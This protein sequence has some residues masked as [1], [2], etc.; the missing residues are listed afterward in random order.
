M[1]NGVMNVLKREMNPHWIKVALD[2]VRITRSV[3]LPSRNDRKQESVTLDP[4]NAVIR[5]DTIHGDSAG[6]GSDPRRWTTPS[7]RVAQFVAA[8]LLSVVC[9]RTALGATVSWTGEGDGVTWQDTRNWNG[10][11]LPGQMDDVDLIDWTDSTI[12][13]TGFVSVASIQCDA[14]LVLTNGSFGVRRGSS[15]VSGSQRAFQFDGGPGVRR[16]A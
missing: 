7:N 10:N 1:T 9:A 15:V 13:S 3:T 2:L 6:G 16:P 5:G 4:M 12:V 8:L 11:V 14:G